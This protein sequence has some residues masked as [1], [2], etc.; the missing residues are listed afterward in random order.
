MERNLTVNS[1][2]SG[3]TY[4]TIEQIGKGGFGEVWKVGV[5]GSKIF[6]AIK[7]LNQKYVD[8]RDVKDK[9]LNSARKAIKL[10][11]QN[12][13][14]IFDYGTIGKTPFIVM[15][16]VNGLDLNKFVKGRGAFEFDKGIS[17][18]KQLLRAL[19]YSHNEGIIHMDIWPP[20]ILMAEDE[21]PKLTD[22]DLAKAKQETE[23]FKQFVQEGSKPGALSGLRRIEVTKQVT[24]FEALVGDYTSPEVENP[25]ESKDIDARADIFSVGKVL[26]FI[27][28][29]T[30]MYGFDF[31][32]QRLGWRAPA[33]IDDILI[34]AI[35]FEKN[36]RFYTAKEF[37]LAIEQGPTKEKRE[38]LREFEQKQ[39]SLIELI[40]QE[41]IGYK[42][43]PKEIIPEIK[44]KYDEIL[45]FVREQHLAGKSIVPRYLTEIDEKMDARKKKDFD[46]I[47]EFHSFI[48]GL[49]S[50]K[51]K[52]EEHES[53]LILYLDQ[54]KYYENVCE[55]WEPQPPNAS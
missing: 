3:T 33:Y 31:I 18:I 37:L 23:E 15:E 10:D 35:A 2:I 8:N 9:F 11:H 50:D 1:L 55:E 14:K 13:V 49:L 5:K 28:T 45:F 44:K 39:R 6:R 53:K 52:C 51:K 38:E 24:S 36:N 4:K 16:Y 7:F 41:E 21:V 47:A 25:A 32:H 43:T 54:L 48:E 19:A 17:V 26:Y 29:G 30:R 22:F 46:T 34:K 27:L 20:N 12:I 40:D 42:V